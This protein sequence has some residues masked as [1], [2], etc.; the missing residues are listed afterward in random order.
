MPVRKA[1]LGWRVFL[2]PPVEDVPSPI[3]TRAAVAVVRP[4]WR[5]TH[6]LVAVGIGREAARVAR[7]LRSGRRSRMGG[8]LTG[9]EDDQTEK[10]PP[11]VHGV[12]IARHLHGLTPSWVS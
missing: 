12:P 4:R 1:A 11:R 10:P 9:R 3:R 5:R 2:D 7:G 8:G 6:G